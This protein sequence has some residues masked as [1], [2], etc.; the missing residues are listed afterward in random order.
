MKRRR[1]AKERRV[2]EFRQVIEQG[3]ATE[4]AAVADQASSAGS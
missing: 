4:T 3:A 2:Q 1:G